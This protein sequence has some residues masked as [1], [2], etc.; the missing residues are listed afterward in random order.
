MS[1]AATVIAY[2]VYTFDSAAV[3]ANHTMMLT[4][5][6]VVYAVFRYLYLVYMRR[7]GG[8]PELL[9]VRDRPLLASIVLWGLSSV[10]ILYIWA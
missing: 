5:P 2:A 8:S 7:L 4:I 3:P 9:L 1:A 6:I 10:A